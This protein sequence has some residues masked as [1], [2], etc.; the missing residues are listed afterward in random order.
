MRQTRQTGTEQHGKESGGDGLWP[1]GGAMDTPS[2]ALYG[3]ALY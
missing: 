2:Y 3:A 1:E